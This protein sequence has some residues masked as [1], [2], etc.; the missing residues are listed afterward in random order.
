M[1]FILIIAIVTFA[2]S[3]YLAF[4]AYRLWKTSPLMGYLRHYLNHG[5]SEE[6]LVEALQQHGWSEHDILQAMKKLK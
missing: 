2:V 4:Y 5:Y 6:E 3:C 1:N